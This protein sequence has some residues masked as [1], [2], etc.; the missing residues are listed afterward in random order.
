MGGVWPPDRPGRRATGESGLRRAGMNWLGVWET[1]YGF[2]G[3]WLGGRPLTGLGDWL[4]G[5]RQRVWETGHE[6][7]ILSL[8]LSWID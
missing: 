4:G 5:D 8:S 3:D 2:A 1:A 6:A 7:G